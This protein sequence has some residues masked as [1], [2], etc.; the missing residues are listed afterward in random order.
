MVG[1]PGEVDS[2]A[3]ADPVEYAADKVSALAWRV[4]ARVRGA[5]DKQPDLVR[6]LH[7]L[8]MLSD[9][10][11]DSPHFANLVGSAMGRDDSRAAEVTGLSIREKISWAIEMLVT[12][13]A[14]PL[15][16]EKFVKGMSYAGGDVV[17]NFDTAIGRMKLLVSHIAG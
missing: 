4:P 2:I 17:P 3:C 10:A 9:R 12:D 11:V 14:Y 16:Y 7:D 13:P 8:A 5:K 15:E 6:H 1:K